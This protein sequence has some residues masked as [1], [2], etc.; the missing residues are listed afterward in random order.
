MTLEEYLSTI[1]HPLAYYKVDESIV[2]EKINFFT[3][4]YKCKVSPTMAILLLDSEI[5]KYV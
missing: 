3:E 4:M 2:Y 1:S 5:G